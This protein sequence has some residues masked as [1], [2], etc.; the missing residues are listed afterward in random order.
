MGVGGCRAA[1]LSCGPAR[2]WESRSSCSHA[3]YML[4]PCGVL[5]AHLLEGVEEELLLLRDRWGHVNRRLGEFGSSAFERVE[6]V[7]AAAAEQPR[8]EGGEAREA[9][10][11]PVGEHA[12]P[13]CS[14]RG[15]AASVVRPG[16][17]MRWALG[18][19]GGSAPHSLASS[20]PLSRAACSSSRT[21]ACDSP[22]ME[23]KR[24][25]RMKTAT[26]R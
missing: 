7:G 16:R 1:R 3:E 6:A 23:R 20:S 9:Q 12:V 26:K 5:H 22:R 17:C 18:A 15:A 4:I 19:V 11:E 2:L 25:S 8:V 14:A 21:A 10:R 24:A 13:V